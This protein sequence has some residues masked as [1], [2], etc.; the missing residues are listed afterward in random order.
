MKS[1]IAL[2]MGDPAGIG[3]EIVLKASRR[4][5][6]DRTCQ[7]FIF[8][9]VDL[10]QFTQKLLL[11]DPQP[12]Q[13][14]F[15]Q[16]TFHDFLTLNPRAFSSHRHVIIDFKNVPLKPYSLGRATAAGGKASGEYI[17]AAVKAALDKKIDAVV[18]AP[19][20]KEAFRMGG[21]GVKYTGHTEML[22]AL[23]HSKSVA[24]MLVYHNFRAVHATSHVALKDVPRILT[25]ERIVDT[26]RLAHEGLK[27]MGIRR[28]LIGVCGLNP[29]A[30]ENG[31]LGTEEKTK[32][33]PA[34]L[35]CRKK[36]INVDGPFSSDVL[37]PHV[38]SKNYDAGIAMYHDQGQIPFKLA[39]FQSDKSN[40]R[41][42]VHGVNVTLGIPIIRTSVAHGTAYD[43]AGKG[44]ADET[45]LFEAVQLAVKMI[46][47]KAV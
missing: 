2:T 37:W 15:D 41:F 25:K 9:D 10:L 30:G 6:G 28:P 45:S 21:W 35:L 33:I 8:G 22:K 26:I 20:N 39:S 13:K 17:Q 34:I 27:K 47:F 24:L 1:R 46:S 16:I 14:R 18:T 11:K 38:L 12:L 43:I 5:L 32:I 23:T 19:I 7:L 4:L 42:N 36:H 44:R 31:L 3:P 29:H 40:G